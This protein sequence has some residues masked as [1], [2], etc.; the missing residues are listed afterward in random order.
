[1]HISIV[2]FYHLAAILPLIYQYTAEYKN[3]ICQFMTNK[4]QLLVYTMSFY[5]WHGYPKHEV[6]VYQIFYSAI[7]SHHRFLN[8]EKELN[9]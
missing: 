1:M 2:T 8:K 7:E 3:H 4:K 5:N 9:I 6:Y